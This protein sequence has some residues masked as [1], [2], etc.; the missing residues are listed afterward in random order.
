[1]D[2]YELSKFLGR[3]RVVSSLV[4]DG[5]AKRLTNI[6]GK[7]FNDHELIEN[8][9]LWERAL[10][11][12]ITDKDYSGFLKFAKKIKSAIERY[13]LMQKMLIIFN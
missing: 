6:I 11:I 8:Y 5:S 9:I 2:K 13:I 3:Y 7:M 4:D 12:F 10:E 1:M